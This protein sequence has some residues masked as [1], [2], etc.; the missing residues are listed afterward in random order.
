MVVYGLRMREEGGFGARFQELG[1]QLQTGRRVIRL[2]KWGPLLARVM[3][4]VRARRKERRRGRVGEVMEEMACVSDAIYYVGDNI[5]L[6]LSPLVDNKTSSP[7]LSGCSRAADLAWGAATIL[8]IPPTLGLLVHML[9]KGDL[10]GARSAL[11]DLI[12]LLLDLVIVLFY[13]PSTPWVPRAAAALSG[14]L[15]GL[16]NLLRS[17][18]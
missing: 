7:L 17:L 6:L 9:Q 2:G 18:Q 16:I 15:A 14:L 12:L 3:D 13:I 1:K 5:H 10:Q 11:W 4:G 8:R